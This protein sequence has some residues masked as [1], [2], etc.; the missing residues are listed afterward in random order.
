MTKEEL[1]QENAVL[2]TANEDL[3]A[4]NDLLRSDFCRVLGFVTREHEFGSWKEKV[5]KKSW[6][7]IFAEIGK[8]TAARNFYDFEGNV[9]ELEVKV[10]RLD[11][12]FH[13]PTDA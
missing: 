1:L 8:L 5:V 12:E 2:K 6:A 4:Q 3:G 9:A 11:Q 13:K 10:S 7:E